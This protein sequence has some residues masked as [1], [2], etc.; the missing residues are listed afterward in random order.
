MHTT[1]GQKELLNFTEL[2]HFK[3]TENEV[4]AATVRDGNCT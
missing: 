1:A 2:I 4:I 3:E